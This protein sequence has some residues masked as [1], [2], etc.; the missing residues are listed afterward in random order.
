MREALTLY[1][2]CIGRALDALSGDSLARVQ[3]LATSIAAAV[4]AAHEWELTAALAPL[5]QKDKALIDDVLA[6][7][8]LLFRDALTTAQAFTSRTVSPAAAELSK[9]LPPARLAALVEAVRE[10]QETRRR[11]VNHTLLLTLMSA[12]LR[13]AAGRE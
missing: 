7:L 12:R 1:D 10:L 2:G 8:V 4:P 5:D 6:A 3:T 9:K 11:H 13:A